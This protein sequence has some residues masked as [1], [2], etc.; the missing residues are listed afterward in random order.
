MLTRRDDELQE[1]LAEKFDR[2]SWHGHY[3][4]TCC[5]YHNE[6]HPSFF[7]YPDGFKC[8][9]CGEWGSLQKLESKLSGTKEVV[10][11]RDE[12]T[13][14]GYAP[15]ATWIKKHK[16]WKGCASYAYRVGR[17]FPPLMS[18]LS[19]RCLSQD[20]IDLGKLG[21]ID[22]WYSFPVFDEYGEMVDWVV[23]SHPSK[24]IELRYAT[25]PREGVN[26]IHLYCPDW[27]RVDESDTV[28]VPFG[29]LDAWTLW[30]AGYP[31]VTGITGQ[32]L[33]PELLDNIR[34]NILIVPDDGEQLGARRLSNALGWRGHV[35]IIEYPEGTKDLNG[36]HQTYGLDFVK[37]LINS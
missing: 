7:V 4:T 32:Q 24:D 18:Y 16:S 34:K 31:V 36:V 10:F 14:A 15:F 5:P 2:V 25:R 6:T 11:R 33:K 35:K 20:A 12:G 9:S 21:Y 37:S 30:M 13:R 28:L 1:K 23:R 17:D 29:I 8:A 3:F 19:K 26:D 22:G 27:M